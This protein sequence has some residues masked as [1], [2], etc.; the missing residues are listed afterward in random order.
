[1]FKFVNKINISTWSSFAVLL[2]KQLC[3]IS[4]RAKDNFVHTDHSAIWLIYTKLKQTDLAKRGLGS[5]SS[6]QIFLL[7]AV[8]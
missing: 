5:F 6:S 3:Y 8:L 7:K 2:K 4:V 1:M